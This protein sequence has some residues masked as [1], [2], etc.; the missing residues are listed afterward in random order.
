[1]TGNYTEIQNYNLNNIM[2]KHFK[3]KNKNY[4]FNFFK[5]LNFTS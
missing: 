1:M 3:L 4:I 2:I 5:L